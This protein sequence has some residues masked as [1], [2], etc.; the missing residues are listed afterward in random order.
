ML[1]RDLLRAFR[2]TVGASAFALATMVGGHAAMAQD[3]VIGVVA[4][5]SGP[6]ASFVKSVV[7]GVEAAVKDW[8][9]AGGHK[10]Q[11]ISLRILDDESVAATAVTVYRKLTDDPQIKVVI[12]CSPAQSL[13]AIKAIADEFKTPTAGSATLDALGVPAAKYFF[14]TLP[15]TE[16]YMRTMVTW[17]A[18]R[19]YKTIA[20]LNPSSVTGQAE[21]ALV[22]RLAEEA[23]LK[24]VAAERYNDS[25][26][27]FTAQLVN[28]RNARPDFFYS[29]AIGGPTVL[30]FK[31]IKQLR[32]TMPLAIHSSA[33]NPTFYSAIG[34]IEQ[35]EGVYT[36]IE[37]GGLGNALAGNAGEMYKRAS[38]ILGRP[39]TNLNTAGWDTAMLVRAVLAKSDASRDSIR[40]AFEAT[41]DLPVIGGVIS[42]TPDNHGGKDERSIAVGQLVKGAFVEAN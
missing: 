13:V 1:K 22:K 27:D 39:A 38:A 11:K 31:Q 17:A 30:I 6:S 15:G 7:E 20:T 32:L 18:K 36:P 2:C 26:T 10:G 4:S 34:G 3:Y 9:D 29:G 24:V 5:M 41:K 16:S 14:R 25:D 23:G 35:A 40:D 8:N 12:A 21:A 33:F 42:Y 28:I 37:R 19:G